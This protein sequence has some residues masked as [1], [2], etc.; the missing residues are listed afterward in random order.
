MPTEDLVKSHYDG[1]ENYGQLRREETVVAECRDNK[2]RPITIEQLNYG[3]NVR[4]GCHTF[5]IENH[6]DVIKAIT[7][8][9]ESPNEVEE[10][11]FKNKK[12]PN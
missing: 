12:L 1:E 7:N 11:W 4:V 3:Y 9:M 5:A 2:I 8:Y 6:G 10:F